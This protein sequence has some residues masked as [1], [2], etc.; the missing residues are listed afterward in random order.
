MLITIVGESCLLILFMILSLVVFVLYGLKALILL[1]YPYTISALKGLTEQVCV[2]CLLVVALLWGF[3]VL[4]LVMT[5]NLLSEGAAF[6]LMVVATIWVR[7]TFVAN[8]LEKAVSPL[9]CYI[10]PYLVKWASYSWPLV[11]LYFWLGN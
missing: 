7:Y 2:F 6:S 11:F 3:L 4:H 5:K 8:L 10:L 1:V 9:V